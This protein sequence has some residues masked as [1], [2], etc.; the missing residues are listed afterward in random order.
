MF[1]LV[2]KK[3]DTDRIEQILEGV[4]YSDNHAISVYELC[5]ILHPLYIDI[6]TKDSRLIGW[7]SSE[8]DYH[9]DMECGPGTMYLC[10]P[11]PVPLAPIENGISVDINNFIQKNEETQNMLKKCNSNLQK[12]KKN[13]NNVVKGFILANVFSVIFGSLAISIACYITKSY[14]PLL[15]FPLIPTW[16]YTNTDKKEDN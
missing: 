7:Y 1:Q 16:K 13:N 14:W 11:N 4:V 3:N 15:A 2:F 8:L 12:L 5:Q 10:L 6:C 9:F